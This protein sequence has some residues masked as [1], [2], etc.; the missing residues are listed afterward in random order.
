MIQSEKNSVVITWAKISCHAMWQQNNKHTIAVNIKSTMQN[1][2]YPIGTS[3]LEIVIYS[4]F[5][6][7]FYKE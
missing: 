1:A 3:S 6:P 7:Y 4:S 2:N 5:V